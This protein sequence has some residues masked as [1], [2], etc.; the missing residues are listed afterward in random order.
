[1]DTTLDDEITKK[2]P[3][4]RKLR[5]VE[6]DDDEEQA[7]TSKAIPSTPAVSNVT[8]STVDA[9]RQ[10]LEALASQRR[11]IMKRDE[12]SDDEVCFDLA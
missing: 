1:M 8:P 12:P 10:K 7:D 3:P 6:S 2:T 4:K 11:K 5:V 9:R